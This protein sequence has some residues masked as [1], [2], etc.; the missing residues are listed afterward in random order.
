MN[1]LVR[2]TARQAVDLLRK[3]QVSPLELLDAA[4]ERIKETEPRLNALPT[5]CLDRARAA[6]RRLMDR[7]PREDETPPGFL[8]GL[9]LAVKDITEVAGVRTTFGSPIFAQHIPARSDHSVEVLEERGGVVTAKSNTPEFGAGANT[10]NEVF[11]ATR[12]PWHTDKN[13][14]GS[15]GG[16]AVALAAGQVW[17]ATGTDLGGSLRIPAAYCSVVGFRPSPGRVPQG[18]VPM[19]FDVLHI[20][21]PMGRTVGDVAMM[22]DAWA[23]AHWGDP[24]SLPRPERSF[25]EAVDRPGPLGRVAYSADLGL[26]PVDAEVREICAGAARRFAELGATVEEAA[27]D[28]GDAEPIFQTL[29]SAWYGLRMEDHYRERRHMLKPELIWQVEAGL[30]LSAREVIAAELARGRL[31]R[32]TAE[33]FRRHDLLLTPAVVVPPFDL[34]IRYLE[35]LDGFK[36]QSYVSWLVLTFAITLCSCPAISVPCG[37]TKSGLPVGGRLGFEPYQFASWG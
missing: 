14:G 12:N 16:S 15:S 22:L 18:P 36:Y 8:H 32:R 3:R 30:K 11:G 37:F 2:L 10:F 24:L 6:A 34:T 5:L 7:W 25:V 20:K 9:P 35:E 17:L 33:F 4:E 27:P 13:C 1:D 26:T 29:R 31:F 28:L 23:G 21:G 19:P